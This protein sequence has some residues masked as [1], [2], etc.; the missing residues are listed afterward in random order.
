MKK[1]YIAIA[2]I[3][4]VIGA[5]L[6]GVAIAKGSP[7][8][9][10]IRRVAGTYQTVSLDSKPD[11]LILRKDG[12]CTYPSGEKGTWKLQNDVILITITV[13]TVDSPI[14]VQ[15]D[16]NLSEIEARSLGSSINVLENVKKISFSAETKTFQVTL[17]DGKN[18]QKTMD[19]LA[20]IE[21]VASVSRDATTT[22]KRTFRGH[23]AE[24]GLVIN[25]QYFK[26]VSN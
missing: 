15:I 5:I 25:G 17:V 3:V 7:E 16:N 24:D 12:T 6:I 19:A 22:E 18:Y 13:E 26:K 11:T 21:G 10:Q 20:A 14:T 8:E 2:I 4:A 1:Y 23:L 9:Q